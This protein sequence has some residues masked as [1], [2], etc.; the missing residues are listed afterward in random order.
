MVP[1]PTFPS[2]AKLLVAI[3][4][5]TVC[6]VIGRNTD[7][8]P[9]ADYHADIKTT[10]FPAQTGHDLDIVVEFDFIKPACTGIDNFS[11]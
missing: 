9:V 2:R 6:G 8:H 10:H 7:R 4:D 11:F 5:E 3:K 1:K